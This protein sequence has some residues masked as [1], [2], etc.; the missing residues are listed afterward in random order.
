MFH[1]NIYVG[2]DGGWG[3]IQESLRKDGE[4][5]FLRLEFKNNC[6]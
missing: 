4:T 2:R 1:F 5:Q 6:W 3:E